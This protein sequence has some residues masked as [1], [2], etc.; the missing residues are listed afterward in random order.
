VQKPFLVNLGKASVA[1]L[2]ISFAVY[3]CIRGI[4]IYKVSWANILEYSLEIPSAE[5]SVPEQERTSV[6]IG[7]RGDAP[8]VNPSWDVK[9]TKP[10]GSVYSVKTMAVQV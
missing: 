5:K 2:A 10:V 9:N 8:S 6:Q 4:Q 3:S 7:L 1:I